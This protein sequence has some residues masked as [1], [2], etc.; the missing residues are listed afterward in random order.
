MLIVS[1]PLTKVTK[2]VAGNEPGAAKVNGIP[3]AAGIPWVAVRVGNAL[4]GRGGFESGHDLM[5][6]AARV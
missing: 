1:S 6:A 2:K 5:K 4:T 3:P